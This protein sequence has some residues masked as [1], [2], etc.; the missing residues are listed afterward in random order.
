MLVAVLLVS[1]TWLHL[2]QGAV[3]LSVSEYL[4]ALTSDDDPIAHAVAI[5]RIP[6]WGAALLVGCCLGAA[7]AGL[8]AR[9]RNPLVAPDTLAVNAG[10]HLAL[11]LSR[12]AGGPAGLV[13]VG[14]VLALAMASVTQVLFLLRS[15]ETQGLFAWG[16]GSLSNPG[17]AAIIQM[18]PV[19][20]AGTIALALVARWLDLLQLGDEPARALGVP[21]R[22]VKVVV[23]VLAV[24]LAAASTAHG[25]GLT[26]QRPWL[27]T[28]VL[29]VLVAAAPVVGLLGGDGW[30]LLGDV[31]NWLQ[32]IASGRISFI[33]DSTYGA[34]LG[35][36]ALLATLLLVA[37]VALLAVHRQLD[38]LQLDADTPRLLGVHLPVNRLLLLAG[39]VVLTAAATTAVGVIG[40]VG[41][42]APHAARVLV[43]PL[44]RRMLPVA[45]LLGALICSLAETAGRA[46]LAPHQVPVGLACALVGAPL[47]VHL[48]SRR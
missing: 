8:Q 5:G 34:T 18:V 33:L 16:A 35:R 28:A 6:R 30:L 19:A 38:V 21:V 23:V 26:Q 7:G 44:H 17:A 39:A 11:A 40:F 25:P 2:T 13:L 22:L 29:A 1:L 37:L 47:F 27:V 46:A 10:A 20:I 31:Q 15:R 3:D 43:G 48:M 41:L 45:V 32:G 36:L 24:M 14:S 42:V 12:R 4:R 9:T